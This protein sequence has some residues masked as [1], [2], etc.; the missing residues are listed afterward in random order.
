MVRHQT[1]VKLSRIISATCAISIKQI[2]FMHLFHFAVG[3]CGVYYLF[4]QSSA[5]HGFLSLLSPSMPSASRARVASLWRPHTISIDAF[6]LF[7][8]AFPSSPARAAFNLFSVASS[9]CL[10]FSNR[11]LFVIS[12]YSLGETTNRAWGLTLLEFFRTCFQ[13]IRAEFYK[14]TPVENK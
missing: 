1:I 3:R 8:T 7:V 12:S 5:R 9:C 11:F 10:K 6:C 4:I 14:L 2:A 13:M